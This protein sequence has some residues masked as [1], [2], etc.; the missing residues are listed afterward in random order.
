MA[1]NIEC[2]VQERFAQERTFGNFRVLSRLIGVYPFWQR[3]F[4]LLATRLHYFCSCYHLTFK[5]LFATFRERNI[6]SPSS[7]EYPSF[8]R[9]NATFVYSNQLI[10]KQPLPIFHFGI[11]TLYFFLP[12]YLVLVSWKL[13]RCKVGTSHLHWKWYW[14]QSS[15]AF[16]KDYLIFHLQRLEWKWKL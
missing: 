12:F 16:A 8:V 14:I 3:I 10:I 5:N 11:L 4:R 1:D 2:F 7:C 6:I 15:A 13:A 9:E